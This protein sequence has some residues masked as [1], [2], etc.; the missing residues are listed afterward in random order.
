MGHL[1]AVIITFNE[2]KNIE[3]CLNSIDQVVDEIIIIDS[4]S[5]DKTEEIARRNPKV[6]FYLKEWMGF[7]ATKNYA[8]SIAE[9]NWIL[10]IDA[11]ECLSTEL[12]NS[13]KELK[14]S[15]P[16]AVASF[17]RKT[18]Y[19]GKWIRFGGWYPDR[20]VRLYDRNTE[21]WEGLVHEKIIFKSPKSIIQLKGDC[22]HY[23]INS[24]SEHLSIIN[25]YSTLSAESDIK[26]G[27]GGSFIRLL[28][29]FQFR[30]FYFYILKLG[31][32]DGIMGLQIACVSSASKFIKELKLLE[33]ERT[34]KIQ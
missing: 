13:I 29:V 19:C 18:L 24:L 10:S 26:K 11:D 4:G 6:K 20:K 22:E 1:S 14:S 15:N 34:G 8:A 30:F 3:R 5:L 17:N 7:S 28:L 21:S 16:G 9:H 25:R 2:A 32:L 33:F 23:S 27:R 31:I 12:R